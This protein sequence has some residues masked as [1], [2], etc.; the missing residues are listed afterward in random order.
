MR[1]VPSDTSI[2][3][4]VNTVHCTVHTRTYC[5]SHCYADVLI[6]NRKT[7][8]NGEKFHLV[9]I[10]LKLKPQIELSTSSCI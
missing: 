7:D 9:E 1:Y 4:S 2:H 6:Q 3:I 10:K 5:L 8:S